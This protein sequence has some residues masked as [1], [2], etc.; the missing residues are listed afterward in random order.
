MLLDQIAMNTGPSWH[1]DVCFATRANLLVIGPDDITAMLLDTVRP[2]LEPPVAIQRGGQPLA[3]P[4]GPVG[5]LILN[6]VW[7]HTL[8]EQAELNEAL[9]GRLGHTQVIST[10]PICLMPMLRDGR[11]L[12]TLYYRLNTILVDVREAPSGP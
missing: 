10:S 2:H 1:L 11:F 7:S 4:A 6:N 9:H 5:T 8:A 12:E 3:L